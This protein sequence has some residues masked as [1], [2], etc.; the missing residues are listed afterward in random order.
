MDDYIITVVKR[1]SDQRIPAPLSFALQDAFH[2]EATV[3]A[4]VKVL[5]AVYPN[6]TF[7]VTKQMGLY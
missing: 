1:T 2:D 4:V 6:L 7:R 3:N 5:K